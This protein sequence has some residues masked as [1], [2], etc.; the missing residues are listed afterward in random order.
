MIVI[1]KI[2]DIRAQSKGM[3]K[4]RFKCGVCSY[5]GIFT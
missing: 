1:D 5:Y 4:R 2:D 3:E